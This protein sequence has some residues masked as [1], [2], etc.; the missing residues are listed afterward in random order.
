M[1]IFSWIVIGFIVGLIFRYGLGWELFFWIFLPIFYLLNIWFTGHYFPE[2]NNNWQGDEYPLYTFIFIFHILITCYIFFIFAVMQ[3]RKRYLNLLNLRRFI[4]ASYFFGLFFLNSFSA[5]I[6]FFLT[7][8]ILFSPFIMMHLVINNHLKNPNNI[9]EAP[10]PP[11]PTYYK[12]CP[13]CA[14]TILDEA[15]KCKYCHSKV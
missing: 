1:S 6:D 8:F 2:V 11:E 3:T 7:F 10:E 12:K 9:P 4:Y 14:E 5:T 13:Y 15:I